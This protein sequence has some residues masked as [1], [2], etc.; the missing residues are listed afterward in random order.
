MLRN[1]PTIA[2]I[3]AIIEQTSDNDK[4]ATM[5]SKKTDKAATSK[6][7]D[8]KTSKA[9]TSKKT[10]AAKQVKNPQVKAINAAAK[11]AAAKQAKPAKPAKRVKPEQVKAEKLTGA[12]YLM[13]KL[14]KRTAYIAA[15]A[16]DKVKIVKATNKFTGAD[17]CA[18]DTNAY[19]ISLFI[20]VK[21]YRSHKFAT[22]KQAAKNGLK[23]KDGAQGVDVFY[24]NRNNKLAYYTVYNVA[25][26][27]AA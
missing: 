19:F 5:T 9:T 13:D 18:D 4:G 14:N 16:A 15:H 8:K 27:V 17:L 20:K 7:T 23:L 12:A 1:Q 25:E 6:K 11:Q 21:K 24:T 26:F 22:I 3:K 10:S 2:S